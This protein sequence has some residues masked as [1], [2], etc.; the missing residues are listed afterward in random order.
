MLDTCSKLN[1]TVG[2]ER[3]FH[4]LLSNK[5]SPYK[6][7]TRKIFVIGVKNENIQST[8]LDLKAENLRL[9]R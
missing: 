7:V 6:W 2:I 9:D 5:I 3:K 8:D 4:V 1:V